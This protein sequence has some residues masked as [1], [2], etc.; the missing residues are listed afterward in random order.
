MLWLREV[1]GKEIKF[2]VLILDPFC[3]LCSFY[4]LG[5]SASCF[6]FLGLSF[7]LIKSG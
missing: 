3:L 1:L 2:G 6:T 5:S 7:F 4:D